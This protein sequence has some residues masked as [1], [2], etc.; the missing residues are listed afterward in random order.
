MPP[1]ERGRVIL[2]LWCHATAYTVVNAGLAASVALSAARIW[3]YRDRGPVRAARTGGHWWAVGAFALASY[4]VAKVRE[5][6]V[7]RFVE[8]SD[9]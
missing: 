9:G 7:V 2:V 6:V 5:S 3:R 8:G 1:E 4:G